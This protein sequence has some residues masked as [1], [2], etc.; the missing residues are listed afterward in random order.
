[1]E[2]VVNN[3]DDLV[4]IFLNS[5]V[6][7]SRLE[8]FPSSNLDRI[9]KN[10]GET[11]LDQALML[12]DILNDDSLRDVLEGP[13]ANRLRD[14]HRKGKQKLQHIW[15][16]HSNLCKAFVENTS[17]IPSSAIRLI[18]S[19]LL[20]LD[21]DLSL[22]EILTNRNISLESE[23]FKAF[24]LLR[25]VI[26]AVSRNEERGLSFERIASYIILHLA[27]HV[28]RI[29][30]SLRY[31]DRTMRGSSSDTKKSFKR[32][33]LLELMCTFLELFSACTA[34]IL[35]ESGRDRSENWSKFQQKL[36]HTLVSPV[37]RHQKI[38]T[39][40]VLQEIA[41]MANCILRQTAV[42]SF[43]AT[44]KPFAAF[45]CSEY[46]EK[47]VFYSVFRRSAQLFIASAVNKDVES[48]QNAILEAVLNS[49]DDRKILFPTLLVRHFH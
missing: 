42:S 9:H 7:S 38:D 36:R 12:L 17:A 39:T 48:L 13:H 22:S 37:L 43:S 11:G 27:N 32:A 30:E 23:A 18:G 8:W 35:R 2:F 21:S 46:L 29:I 47:E 44:T 49:A 40:G 25:N 26:T 1:M 33:R 15:E 34:W 45:S 6:D 16:F 28:L 19:S 3:A 5:L 10:A 41:T 24:R 31:H 4:L 20:H 14:W